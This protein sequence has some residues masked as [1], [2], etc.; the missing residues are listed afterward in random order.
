MC[1]GLLW[2]R[3]NRSE[4]I[5]CHA[6]R[7][8]LIGANCPGWSVAAPTAA[9]TLQCD[10]A[11]HPGAFAYPER[12]PSIVPTVQSARTGSSTGC[13]RSSNDWSRAQWGPETANAAL[14]EDRAYEHCVLLI[15]RIVCA[16]WLAS[17]NF[18]PTGTVLFAPTM[19]Y[20]GPFAVL[21]LVTKTVFTFV[22]QQSEPTATTHSAADLNGWTPKPTQAP[23]DPRY[24]GIEQRNLFGRQLQGEICA[25]ID[26]NESTPIYCNSGASCGWYTDPNY[27]VC[28][29]TDSSSG[30]IENGP[31]CASASAC[32]GYSL[33]YLA[34]YVTDILTTLDNVLW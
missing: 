28:C 31:G 20:R 33:N 13:S 22:I 21:L 29:A 8:Q 4:A 2:I 6:A 30:Y 11:R 10:R 17:R 32:I 27:F 12:M 18:T 5:V 3:G 16:I 9:Q 23:L 14:L 7:S 34:A 15:L 25:Y 19:P 1:T 26:G 24:A